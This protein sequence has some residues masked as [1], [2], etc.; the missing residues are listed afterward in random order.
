MTL[1]EVN[2]LLAADGIEPVDTG[3]ILRWERSGWLP[4]TPRRSG[5]RDFDLSAVQ[6]IRALASSPN[7]HRQ[8]RPPKGASG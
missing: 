8:G 1:G 6:R 5:W 7:R 3:A 2:E 4:P